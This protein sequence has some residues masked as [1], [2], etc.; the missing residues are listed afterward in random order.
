MKLATFVVFLLTIVILSVVASASSAKNPIATGWWKRDCQDP[1]GLR[2]AQAGPATYSISF[3]GPGGCSELGAYRP[4]SPIYGDDRYRV[5][6]ADTI[7]VAGRDGWSRYRRCDTAAVS[8]TAKIATTSKR[9]D[10][11]AHVVIGSNV[12]ELFDTYRGLYA[13][14][15][16]LGE[17][18]YEACNQKTLTV[19]SF[20]EEPW[21][22]GRVTRI[23]VHKA[24]APSVCRDEEGSLPEASVPPSTSRG[25][26]IGD[27]AERVRDL[28]G[29]PSES[30]ARDQKVTLLYRF[31]N[32]DAKDVQIMNR[33]LSVTLQGDTVTSMTLSGDIPGAQKPSDR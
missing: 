10:S 31:E 13:H 15:L 6:D 16:T 32:A 30:K 8:G 17:V 29:A 14:G 21:S 3:C 11:L 27:S 2:I 7:D 19:Y 9:E 20:V 4:N 28:Y 24:E 18:L 33:M 22:R 23:W 5:I 25:L 1:F 26:S 12:A